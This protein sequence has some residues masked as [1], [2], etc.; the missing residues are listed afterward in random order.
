[1]TFPENIPLFS[2]L[3]KIARHS[4]TPLDLVSRRTTVEKL[5]ELVLSGLP[6]GPSD[7]IDLLQQLR[8][9]LKDTPTDAVNVLVFG[10]GTGLSTIIGGDSRE[11]DWPST[12]F[13][14][15]KDVFPK[16]R[17]VVCV[18]DDGGS[19]GELLKDLP[20]IGL[21]DL[22]HVLLA[23]LRKE[24]LQKIYALDD[25]ACV[26]LVGNLHVLFNF[27][28]FTCPDS[29]EDLLCL[30]GIELSSLPVFLAKELNGLLESMFQSKLLFDA[31]HRP[32]C[33]GNLLL[34]AAIIQ[35]DP[36]QTGRTPGSVKD[37]VNFIAQLIGVEQD[38]VLPCTVTPCQLKL[39]YNNGVL[40]TGE[41]K[42]AQARRGCPVDHVFVEFVESPQVLPEVFREI[43]QADI[44]IYAPGSIYTSIVPVLQVPGIS[45]AIRQN[46][47]AVKI[48][49]ANIW[50]QA[51][52]TDI[53]LDAPDR[54]Y[55]VSDLI[56]AYQRNIPKGIT[57]IFQ[58]VMS[59][60]LRDIPGSIIQNYAVEGKTPIYLDRGKVWG[61]GLVPVEANIFSQK[62][63]LAR[64]VKHDPVSFAQA[65]KT[66]WLGRANLDDAACRKNENLGDPTVFSS[67]E[68]GIHSCRRFQEM[69]AILKRKDFAEIDQVA[70][71]LWRHKDISVDHLEFVEG[72]EL[73]DVE[74]WRRSQKWDNV[75]SFYDPDDRLIKIQKNVVSDLKKFEVAFL[76]A[77]GQ[78]LLGNYSLEK[79]IKP[80][81]QEGNQV[82]RM[83]QVL[84]RDSDDLYSYFSRQELE[85]YLAV[86]RMNR[87]K[88]SDALF[89]RVLNGS[90]GFTPPGMLF[91]LIY[92]WYLDNQ[93]ASHIEYKMSI[94]RMP[95]SYLVPEQIKSAGRR[96]ATIKF[97]REKVFRQ[98]IEMNG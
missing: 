88:G 42:S 28:F 26:K 16:S 36:Y 95:I 50:A 10:G 78:S 46:K 51:G 21:G 71:I 6:D 87:S 84:L 41:D 4:L 85:E 1:M 67:M 47:K 72:L 24:T 5:I 9:S 22:R 29:V 64:T 12:P 75:Y 15:L 3:D 61:M 68:Y 82:G 55:Y 70:E 32:Q 45:D 31:L 27:R 76:V 37:G 38:Y 65:V 63:L 18:T 81:L 91:G 39:L 98:R 86:A 83:Y 58:V 54:R 35:H 40:T 52:E 48:L 69:Y 49:V 89:L 44:I 66:L 20:L 23:A 79:Q 73:I 19:T 17:A 30:L 90:E 7:S 60:G 56:K 94:T 59:L 43:E 11:S 53:A 25:D 8:N 93:L 80:L 96:K 34:A 14:G 92:A 62:A 13:H 97:F 74:M 33:L 2:C 77:L 57:D